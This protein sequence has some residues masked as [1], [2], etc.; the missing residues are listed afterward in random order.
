MSYSLEELRELGS[1]KIHNDTHIIKSHI[2]TILDED[3][4]SIN[5]V[6][7]FGFLSIIEKEY[8]LDLTSIRENARDFYNEQES[9]SDEHG[10]VFVTASKTKKSSL[11]Y[12]ILILVVF[13][14]VAFFSLER[15]P[16]NSSVESG[17]KIIEEVKKNISSVQDEP[18]IK[19]KPIIKEIIEKKE[20]KVVIKK[21]KKI[22]QEMKEE[23]KV[24]PKMIKEE[25]KPLKKIVKETKKEA[26]IIKKESKPQELAIT[27]SLSI[28]PKSKVW[29]GYINITKNRKYQKILSKKFD[30]DPTQ[31]WLMILGH[32]NVIFNLNGKEIEYKHRKSLRL[33]YK[34][35]VLK[36]VTLEEFKKINRGKKW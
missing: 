26:V 23:E 32:S 16:K 12:I 15:T 14:S 8:D 19:K 27:H 24:K 31:E 4:E 36:E 21:P 13:I 5:K 30:F 3:F 7:M 9:E 35:G 6:Q 2:E 17:S 33:S 1:Q 25:K 34:D 10:S 28:V 18:I 11:L 20:E 22:L 29:I